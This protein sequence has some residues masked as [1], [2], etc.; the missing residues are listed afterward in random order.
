[1]LFNENLSQSCALTGGPDTTLFGLF[2]PVD[3]ANLNSLGAY[4]YWFLT[5]NFKINQYTGVQ[6][7]YDNSCS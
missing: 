1:M 6:P 4:R 2:T 3:P 5:R 7:C